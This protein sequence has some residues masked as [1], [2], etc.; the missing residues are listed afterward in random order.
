MADLEGSPGVQTRHLAEALQLRTTEAPV[1]GG[2]PELGIADLTRAAWYTS[3]ASATAVE[4][5]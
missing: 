5:S 4:G 3:E 1:P 2:A